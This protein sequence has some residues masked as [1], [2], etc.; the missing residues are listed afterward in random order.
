M[1]IKDLLH[2]YT[3]KN[4]IFFEE[5]Q[6]LDEKQIMFIPE[7]DD[8]WNIYKHITHLVQTQIESLNRTILLLTDSSEINVI[9]ER[10]NWLNLLSG[11]NISYKVSINLLDAI[12]K[13]E[14]ALFEKISYKEIESKQ[15]K[16]KYNGEIDHMNLVENIESAIYHI[17]YHYKYIERNIS[18][19]K[20]KEKDF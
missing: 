15:L 9:S 1:I 6:R 11:L 7:L 19:Y 5:L 12:Y 16:C 20:K 2:E 10:E 17:D 8:S 3:K 13:Y 14:L 4:E 18:E